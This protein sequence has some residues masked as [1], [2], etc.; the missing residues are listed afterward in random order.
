MF[1]F[2]TA[3][4]KIEFLIKLAAFGLAFYYILDYIFV[5]EVS[6]VIGL[7]ALVI[8]IIAIAILHYFFGRKKFCPTCKK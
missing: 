6:N 4:K 2:P 7:T 3:F 5:C 8:I 1:Q